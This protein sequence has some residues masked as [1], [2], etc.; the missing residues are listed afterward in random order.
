MKE[1]KV[2]ICMTAYN[3]AE[4]IR[5]MLDSILL[6]TE[7]R[8]EVIAIDNGSTDAT[9]TILREYALKDER[10]RV[11]TIPHGTIANGRQAGMNLA[12][13]DYLFFPDADDTMPP[14]GLLRLL[15]KAEKTGADVVT[16]GYYTD[17][18]GRRRMY[19]WPHIG[20]DAFRRLTADCPL[21]N[22]LFRRRFLEQWGIEFEDTAYGE[23][24]LFCSRVAR[25][26]P[27]IAMELHSVY[28]YRGYQSV[29]APSVTNQWT[30]E[31]FR[32]TV[33]M[34]DMYQ[35]GFAETKWQEAAD[36]WV[37]REGA[38]QLK[39]FLFHLWEPSDRE[40]AFAIFQSR[41]RCFDWEGREDAFRGIYSMKIEDFFRVNCR[42][43]MEQ[44]GII[45][46]NRAILE[47]YR[48]GQQGLRFAVQCA[49]EWFLFKKNRM[50]GK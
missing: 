25:A 44:C 15:R 6:Q 11:V 47:G 48:Q 9:G 19:N 3:A 34:L 10:L 29:F 41:A 18:G 43:Y 32:A 45:D 4:H 12:Q 50:L 27:K 39:E 49:F 16:G 17:T 42:T 30:I 26:E 38:R 33:K 20:G 35:T 24:L 22:K 7:K 2:S 13:G 40:T 28:T 36:D 5:R 31:R 14:E 21:W 1:V 23:D 46:P 37:R 8:F